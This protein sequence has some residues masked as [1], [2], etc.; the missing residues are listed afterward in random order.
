MI[1]GAIILRDIPK[2]QVLI[3]LNSYPIQGGFRGFSMVPPGLHYVKIKSGRNY[4]GFWHFLKPSE[5][6]VKVFD[7]ESNSFV[8]DST[9]ST[10]NYRNLALS[11]NMGTALRPY[12]HESFGAWFGLIQNISE[13]NFPPIIYPI[14]SG[15]GK[16]FEMAFKNTHSRNI[17][18]FL[19]EFQY[20]FSAWLMSS[21]NEKENAKAYERWKHLLLS[22]Y[23][24]GESIMSEYPSLFSKLTDTII[25]QFDTLSL[26]WFKPDSYIVSQINYLIED[27][28]DCAK[29]DLAIKSG[30]LSAYIKKR[31]G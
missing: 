8:N 11:G 13:N 6:I 22:L 1:L 15:S 26:E 16:R 20:A 12:Q 2:E 17:D 28:K 23:N 7:Y 18:S 25:H 3:D 5:V 21:G 29:E 27:M 30:E 14:E 9:E 4:Y 19:S 31:M 10:E 24:A